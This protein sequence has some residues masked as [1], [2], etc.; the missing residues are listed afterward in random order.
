[1]REQPLTPLSIETTTP[2]RY[3]E[4]VEGPSHDDSLA[5]AERLRSIT[6]SLDHHQVPGGRTPTRRLTATAVARD[7]DQHQAKQRSQK[8]KSDVKYQ[9]LQ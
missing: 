1:M 3:P 8:K 4:D 6:D 5:L 7:Q 2:P 9:A